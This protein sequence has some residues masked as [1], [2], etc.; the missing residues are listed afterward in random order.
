MVL[1]KYLVNG[2]ITAKI[3]GIQKEIW[4]QKK[5]ISTRF[6]IAVRKDFLEII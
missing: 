1:K 4:K 2:L 3:G 6:K 5:D